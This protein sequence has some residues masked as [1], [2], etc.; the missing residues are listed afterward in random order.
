MTLKMPSTRI[1]WTQ[2]ICGNFWAT[3]FYLFNSRW[4]QALRTKQVTQ[5][6]KHQ[7]ADRTLRIKCDSIVDEVGKKSAE[8]FEQIELASW[9]PVLNG[10]IFVL[11]NGNI[12][13]SVRLN[14]F[15]WILCLQHAY[16]VTQFF[17]SQRRKYVNACLTLFPRS[18][19]EQSTIFKVHQLRYNLCEA[20]G[21]CSE[22]WKKKVNR[23]QS[24]GN[25]VF[26]FTM[27]V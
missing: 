19:L 8:N 7:L 16:S 2:E 23:D 9:Q 26:C 1:S 5:I 14:T 24:T 11:L 10:H 3:S 17:L 20:Y 13:L 18:T 4:P 6:E 12:V 27:T 21:T 15:D 25:K 22:E